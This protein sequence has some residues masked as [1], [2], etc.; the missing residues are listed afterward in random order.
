MTEEPIV[1]E[2]KDCFPFE[3][4]E[5]NSEAIQYFIS[6]QKQLNI[7]N[8]SDKQADEDLEIAYFNNRDA[9]WYAGRLVGEAEFNFKGVVYRIVIKP[10][11]GNLQLFRMLE[12]VFNIKLSESKE[13]ITRKN[14]YQY[15]IKQL[16]AFLWLNL[17]SKANKHGL[18]KH[19]VV[20]R[21]KGAVV[22]GRLNVKRSIMPLFTE[23][24]IVSNYNE[25]VV[26]SNVATILFKAY[27]I[28]K[29][30]YNLSSI[31]ASLAA[32]N[33]TEQIFNSN[34]RNAYISEQD[35]KNIR[36][37]E[38]Y[39]S[40]KP[41]VDLSWDIIK[42]KEFGS[43]KDNSSNTL[44]FFIDMAEVWEVYLRSILR[45][46]FAKY[47]WKLRKDKIQTY[48][49]KN[50]RRLMIPDIVLEK[51]E[52]IMVWDAKYKRMKYDYFDYDRAD[53]F[54]IHTYI[55]YYNQNKNVVAGGL[56][57][58]LSK[59]FTKDMQE[60]NKANSLFSLNQSTTKFLVDGIEYTELS[61]D[62]IRSEEKKFLERIVNL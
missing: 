57:Y 32:K 11:F 12:E 7:F 61:E 33:A 52:K 14:D 54:Q 45:K 6:N 39:R 31:K 9:K 56:L 25:K 21:Y 35:Y 4:Q 40:F 1:I 22:R 41:V 29:N 38:I 46:H 2:A 18:P 42:K 28:L 10:R 53:F 3:N 47:G 37:K 51:G 60:R 30:E 49:Q 48:R 36:Y 23:E 8:I 43:N 58:P 55:K 59:E 15:L 24:K 26:D 13:T 27:Q 44:S 19:N 62:K 5:G 17:L 34:I 50:F 16:I 20:R